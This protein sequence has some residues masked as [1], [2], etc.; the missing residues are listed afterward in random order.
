MEKLKPSFFSFWIDNYKVSFL[1]FFLI[2]IA[3]I[4]AMISIPKESS[5]DIKFG[6]ISI[7]TRYPG[8]NP[9]DIDS[10]ITEKIENEIESIDGISKISSTSS[11]GLS[12]VIIEFKNGVDTRNALTDV[13]DEV[14]SIVFPDDVNDPIIQEISSDSDVMFE[15]L[16]Y[17]DSA[18]YSSFDLMQ[19]ARKMEQDLEGKYGI[20]SIDI[21]GVS[22]D[23]YAASSS[24][25]E[26]DIMVRI[27]QGKME[28]LGLSLS[29]I[30]NTIRAYNQNTPLGNY[31]I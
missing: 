31:R 10:I 6:I 29:S 20:D 19:L 25:N 17:G 26:Y 8:V 11:V 1:I 30:A 28:A 18:I 21:G 27:S 2:I 12:S 4:S 13:K 9:Q 3:G 5:P 16:L 24:A 7:M 15:A 22:S 23:P 14:D